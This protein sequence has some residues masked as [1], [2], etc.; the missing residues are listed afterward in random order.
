MVYIYLR[1]KVFEN[2]L[3]RRYENKESIFYINHGHVHHSMA[4][5]YLRTPVWFAYILVSGR[6]AHFIKS[7]QPLCI[8]EPRY[9]HVSGLQ[10]G[11]HLNTKPT[12]QY[13]AM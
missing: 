2:P 10:M 6:L 11:T 1:F 9:F 7:T 13:D 3:L 4:L 8:W 12:F 5:Q